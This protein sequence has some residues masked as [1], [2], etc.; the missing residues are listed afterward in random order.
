MSYL[1]DRQAKRKKFLKIA[2]GFALLALLFY[3][4][5][6]LFV[7]LSL[8]TGEILRPVLVLGQDTGTR[9]SGLGAYFSSKSAL[10]RE[11][12][13]LWSQ[14]VRSEARMADY[15]IIVRENESLKEI[16]SRQPED[17]KFILAAVLAKPGVSPYDTL[18]LDL[19]AKD[20][21]I[22]G[23]LI[24]AEG[25]IPIGRLASVTSDTAKAVLFS[26]T[27]ER[28]PVIVPSSSIPAGESNLF[29]EI[30]E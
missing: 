14:L 12:E 24:F 28:T 13:K 15:Q 21:A 22:I 2:G 7:G 10:E 27:R 25:D 5:A 29:L 11:N 6:G 18:L 3:F 23:N 9:L 19:G 16:L 30:I 26:S 1:Q 20:G 8:A 4:R 17:K